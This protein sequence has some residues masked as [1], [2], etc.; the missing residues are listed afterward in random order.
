MNTCR[1][2]KDDESVTFR[3]SNNYR[4]IEFY[5]DA[6]MFSSSIPTGKCLHL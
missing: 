6:Y 3:K 5:G 2:A 4:K 1:K